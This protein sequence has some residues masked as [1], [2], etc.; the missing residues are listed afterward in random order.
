MLGGEPELERSMTVAQGIEKMLSLYGELH[1]RKAASTMQTT[2]DKY[3]LRTT[4][5][6]TNP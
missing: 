4:K 3:F 2:L 5:T 1:D 6:K